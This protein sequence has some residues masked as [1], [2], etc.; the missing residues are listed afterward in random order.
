MKNIGQKLDISS[1]EIA[2][3]VVLGLTLILAFARM[4]IKISKFHR[5]FVD[6]VF[7]I[8]AMIFLV[9]GTTMMFLTLPY[10]Q[11][12]QDV[13]AGVEAPPP[14]INHQLDMDVKF[15]D[16]A[17]LLLNACIYSV[18]FSFLFFFRHL[19]SRTKQLKV[20][21]WCI[22]IFTIPCAI[23]CMC[24]E[25]IACP[26]FGDRIMAV[27]VSNSAL[28]RQL[29]DLYVT[30]GLDILTDLLLISIPILLLW[31]VKINIRRKLGLASLLSLSIF[32]IITT[33]IRAAGHKLNNGQD[34]VTWILFWFE[35]EACVAVCA[36]SMT[37]FRS[38]FVTASSRIRG[39]P[40]GE[41]LSPVHKPKQQR[42]VP[43]IEMPTMPT[44]TFSGMKSMMRK[45]PFEDHEMTE[46]DGTLNGS[47]IQVTQS[48]DARSS[49]RSHSIHQDQLDTKKFSH[50]TFV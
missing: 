27:C 28:K 35:I 5:L 4:C 39:S 8:L 44:A 31:N 34:D 21:W 41:D 15:Q 26:A 2:S 18:K 50:E 16:T 45:D 9:A 29:T 30:T 42:W 49:H 33:I 17:V 23:V 14:D 40:H 13:G 3:G 6:D 1:F 19:L 47:T 22:F 7:F 37:A 36:N 38:L 46:S 32:A 43:R 11:T 25:F 10:N 12:G 20:W 48:F 24:T